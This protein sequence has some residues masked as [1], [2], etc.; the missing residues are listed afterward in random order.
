MVPG[1]NIINVPSNLRDFLSFN[2]IFHFQTVGRIYVENDNFDKNDDFWA[3]TNLWCKNQSF[4]HPKMLIP[5]KKTSSQKWFFY[6]SVFFIRN[7]W[8]LAR[9]WRFQVDLGRIQISNEKISN[10]GAKIFYTWVFILSILNSRS[11]SFIE[12]SVTNEFYFW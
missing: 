3:K 11:P 2:I 8:F 10:F 6:K 9:K 4:F 12:L 7:G 1:V 5:R